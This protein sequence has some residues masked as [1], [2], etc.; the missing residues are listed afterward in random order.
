MSV[1]KTLAVLMGSGLLLGTAQLPAAPTA[2]MLGD[3]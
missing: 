2:G 3:T 1:R